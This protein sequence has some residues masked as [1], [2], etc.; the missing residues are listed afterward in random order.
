MPDWN[1]IVHMTNVD[2]IRKEYLKDYSDYVHRNAISYYSGWLQKPQLQIR[3]FGI[4]DDDINAFMTCI[5]G[6]NCE[7]GLDLILHTPGG[8]VAATES[9]INYLHEIFNG[10]IRVIIPHLAMSGGTMIACASKEIW[11]GKESYIGP[12]DPQI[13]GRPAHGY[14]EARNRAYKEIV[15]RDYETGEKVHTRDDDEIRRAALFWRIFLEK[16]DM[17]FV[18]ECEKGME[19]SKEIAKQGLSNVMFRNDDNADGKKEERIQN[20]VDY[21][22]DH[23]ETKE[24]SRHIPAKKAQEMHLNVEMIE[25]DQ[26]M[27][28]KVLS[29]HHAYVCTFQRT[30]AVKI[31]E[32]QDGKCYI[33][34]YKEGS[35]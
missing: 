31:V 11:M 28:E 14:V 29:V 20:I 10:D 9:L 13:N 1:D 27:Q 17:G 4:N 2:V 33:I 25:S 6:L 3:Q 30:D 32:N 22:S 19:L 16:Y 21:L 7:K 15:G 8:N 35:K 24:H 18:I 12:I 26:K 34:K 5:H 23:G